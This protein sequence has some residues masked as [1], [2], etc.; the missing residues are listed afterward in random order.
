MDETYRGLFT[1]IIT[2]I[3]SLIGVPVIQFLKNAFGWEDKSATVAAV[4]VAA[5][6]AIVEMFLTDQLD[7]AKFSIESFPSIFFG[8]Y[9]VATVYYQLFKNATGFLGEDFM[10]RS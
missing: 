8:V 10:I 5:I 3:T 9:T 2:L 6:L 7:L 4:A 1:L